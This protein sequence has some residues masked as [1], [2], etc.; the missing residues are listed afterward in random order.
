MAA[1]GISISGMAKRRGGAQS[2]IMP[3]KSGEGGIEAKSIHE[4][5]QHS[6]K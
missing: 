1:A 3:A 6:V 2:K 4:N 5:Y